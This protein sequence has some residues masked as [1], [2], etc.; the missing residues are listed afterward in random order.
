MP[1]K[2]AAKTSG[3]GGKG[4]GKDGDVQDV[5]FQMRK[6]RVEVAKFCSELRIPPELD[7][8]KLFNTKIYDALVENSGKMIFQ[9]DRP[10]RA[11]VQALSCILRE[12]C[13][14]YISIR[15]LF[16]WRTEVGD[17]G[18]ASIC[19]NCLDKGKNESHNWPGFVHLELFDVKMSALGCQSL[20]RS[21]RENIPL[22]N[23]VI[24]HNAIG[25]EGAT[26]LAEGLRGNSELSFLSMAYCHIG[27]AGGVVVG[28]EIVRCTKIKQLKLRGNRIMARGLTAISLNLGKSESLVQLDLSDNSI[29]SDIHAVNAFCEALRTNVSLETVDFEHNVVGAEATAL[30]AETLQMCPNIK[31]FKACGQVKRLGQ[32]EKG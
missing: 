7:I 27:P 19:E 23:L 20:S 29:L 22:R 13:P 26:H 15:S 17:E 3:K 6:V 11:G 2:A 21:L 12:T 31:S 10:G 18:V 4:K 24:D 32:E 9:G 28:E 8:E 16:F 1:K 14:V 5:S 30:I 25:D